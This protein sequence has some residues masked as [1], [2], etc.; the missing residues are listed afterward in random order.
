MHDIGQVLLFFVFVR[1]LHGIP[2]V[3]MKLKYILAEKSLINCTVL[4]YSR[5]TFIGFL[6]SVV[7]ICVTEY[8]HLSGNFQLG[9]RD[10]LLEV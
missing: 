9:R 7:A 5:E 1:L 6:S 10:G 3:F 2:S 8:N 4:C